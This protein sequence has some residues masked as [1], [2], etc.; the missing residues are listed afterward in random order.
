MMLLYN[1]AVYVCGR[2]RISDHASGIISVRPKRERSSSLLPRM[3]SLMHVRS[4]WMKKRKE[5]DNAL[6]FSFY[7]AI[8]IGEDIKK[9]GG[10]D[11]IEM[12]HVSITPMFGC[13]SQ[14]R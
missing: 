3:G 1:N 5:W 12:R 10:N 14:P 7:R 2:T 13:D 8:Q 9:G 11:Y 6:L 4:H